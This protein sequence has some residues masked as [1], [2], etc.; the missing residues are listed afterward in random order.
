MGDRTADLVL[1]NGFADPKIAGSAVRR[2]RPSLRRIGCELI[3]IESKWIFR[4]WHIKLVKDDLHSGRG[5]QREAQSAVELIA[6]RSTVVAIP[7]KLERTVIRDDS[8]R[9]RTPCVLP[10]STLQAIRATVGLGA[11]LWG[12]RGFAGKGLNHAARCVAIELC[13]RTTK[14]FDALGRG[15]TN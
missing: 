1:G 11:E 14:D 2:S 6:F 10:V 13:Q 15:Q 9:A 4:E 7:I 3:S 12:F 8:D 5:C